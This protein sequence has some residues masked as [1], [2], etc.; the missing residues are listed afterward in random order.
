MDEIEDLTFM[1]KFRHYS[2]ENLVTAE[3]KLGEFNSV[4]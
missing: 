3:S 4:A 2:I 1:S